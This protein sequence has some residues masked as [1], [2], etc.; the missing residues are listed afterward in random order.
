MWIL[1]TKYFVA[2][3]TRNIFHDFT[4]NLWLYEHLCKI[5][6]KWKLAF[7]TFVIFYTFMNCFVSSTLHHFIFCEIIFM[8]IFVKL[9]FTHVTFVYLSF[10]M[11]YPYMSFQVFR[12]SKGF[13]TNTFVNF[14]TFMNFISSEFFL[15]SSF[16]WT[17]QICYFNFTWFFFKC[18]AACVTF[19]WIWFY[20]FRNEKSTEGHY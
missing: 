4:K 8:R 17:L 12:L 16:S 5:W 7:C 9:I 20:F 3:V 15:Y 11:N 14:F 19:S 2:I 13:A 10:F 1:C 6:E 18:F